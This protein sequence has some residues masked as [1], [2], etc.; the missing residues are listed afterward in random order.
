MVCSSELTPCAHP[1]PQIL[2][3]VLRFTTLS[4]VL[5]QDDNEVVKPDLVPGGKRQQRNVPCLLD[6]AG[7]AALVRGAYT[8]EPPGYDLAALGHKPLQQTDIAVGDRIDLLG[9]ELAD[10]F[11]AEE[12]SAAAGSGRGPCAGSA[13]WPAA[14]AMPSAGAVSRTGVGARAETGARTGIRT[15]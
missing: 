12:L 2:R 11:A 1:E 13:R 15:G 5:A 3:L 8:G 10:L 4:V 9:A 6:G 14:R 7:Q